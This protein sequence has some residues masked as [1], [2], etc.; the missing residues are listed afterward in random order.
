M[1]A[2]EV[3]AAKQL[4]AAFY[5]SVL[6]ASAFYASAFYASSLY[7]SA[8]YASVF[9]ASALYASAFYAS[10]FYASLQLRQFV[11]REMHIEYW[12]PV[13]STPPPD[14]V[15]HRNIVVLGSRTRGRLLPQP[16][17]DP[18]EEQQEISEE[19]E[20]I[21][22]TRKIAYGYIAPVCIAVGILGN[23]FTILVLMHTRFKGMTYTF[24]RILA[25]SDLLSL[26][27]C[28]SF[29]IHLLQPMTPSYSTAYWYAHFEGF[30][31]NVP[32]TISVFTTVLITI[33]RYFSVCRPTQFKKI[34]SQQYA[35]IG[36]SAT[37]ATAAIIW[38][39]VCF[40]K[41]VR[42]Y[43][44]CE[45]YSFDRPP[46]NNQTHYVACM[47]KNTLESPAYMFYSWTRQTV[48]AFIPIILLIVLNVLIIK[49]Y[50]GV[51]KRREGLRQARA[52][53]DKGGKNNWSTKEDRNLIRMLCA[54]MIS[55]SITMFPPGI[56][57]AVYT[58]FLSSKLE[59]EI[60]RAI[61]NDLEILNH[62]TN[63][64]LYM[65]LSRPV[66]AA[67]KGYFTKAVDEIDSL[68][69]SENRSKTQ[70]R[71]AV[72]V[73]ASTQAQIHDAAKLSESP[74]ENNSAH[75]PVS[76][77][78]LVTEDCQAS[79]SSIETHEHVPGGA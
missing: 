52:D 67:V 29:V 51:A 76:R 42:E 77:I 11:F 64:Y 44:D 74:T 78:S 27:F 21:W 31:T 6:Y 56:A 15:L 18:F 40:M 34:H 23:V 41:D 69:N 20:L 37:V 57:N 45:S 71:D 12:L 43:T 16:V 30:V 13:P 24:F 66:R 39:P 32:M 3:G 70:P 58:E 73:L 59:Y 14:V 33:E 19:E 75:R 65:L 61:A 36:F 48:V 26:I 17:Q 46:K 9:Y 35:K 68:K 1:E 62:A 60:F 79:N 49:A 4:C 28:I 47:E 25:W 63:F 38:L 8:F 22:T 5:V 54:V 10:V 53:N 55:F 7:A 2:E 72:E 50:I